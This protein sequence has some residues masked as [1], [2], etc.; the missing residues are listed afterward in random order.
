MDTFADGEFLEARQQIT[1]VIKLQGKKLSLQLI[2]VK[3]M[4]EPDIHCQEGANIR[5]SVNQLDGNRNKPGHWD[6]ELVNQ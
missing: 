6:T 4:C 1:E 5:N 3:M 2:C